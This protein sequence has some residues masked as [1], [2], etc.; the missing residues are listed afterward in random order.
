[1]N[2]DNLEPLKKFA[3]RDLKLDLINTAQTIVFIMLASYFYK[4]FGF[5]TTIPIVAISG[6]VVIWFVLMV[7][8]I[9]KQ[10]KNVID[11]DKKYRD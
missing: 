6:I 11:I 2:T 5:S 4:N 3:G 9:R 7:Y 10:S 8:I 1:M